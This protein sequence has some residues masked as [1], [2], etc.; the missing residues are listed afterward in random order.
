MIL[1]LIMILFSLPISAISAFASTSGGSSGGTQ[2]AAVDPSKPKANVSSLYYELRDNGNYWVLPDDS[3]KFYF[4][5]YLDKAPESGEDV[6]VYY[7]T[8]DESA[9]SE[10]GDYES[11]GTQGDKY[12]TLARSND[13]RARVTVKSSII[14]DGF[15]NSADYIVSRSFYFDLI[16]VEGDAAVI[17]P[18]KTNKFENTSRL[19]CTLRAERYHPYVVNSYDSRVWFNEVAGLC[20]PWMVQIWPEPLGDTVYTYQMGLN[21]SDAW[22]NL[23]ASGYYDLGVSMY[24]WCV[25]P[26][27]DD[28][29]ILYTTLMYQKH[30]AWFPAVSLY[31]EGEWD[32][33]QY[34]GWERAY[35]YIEKVESGAYIWDVEKD[36]MKDNFLGFRVYDNLGN[37]EYEVYEPITTY[38]GVRWDYQV[39][40]LVAKLKQALV[41]GMLLQSSNRHYY[42]SALH[43]QDVYYLKVPSSFIN[44]DG[45][46]ITIESKTSHSPRELDL[47]LVASLIE[48]GNPTIA[49]TGTGNNQVKMVKTNI[50]E[51]SSG[52][53]IRLSVRFDRP[54]QVNNPENCYVTA[55]ING[56]YD[57]KLK[58]VDRPIGDTLVFEG[59]I[60]NEAK[61]IRIQNLRNIAFNKDCIAN[62]TNFLNYNHLLGDGSI[63]DI[64]SGYDCDLRAPLATVNT[65]KSESWAKSKSVDI[66]VSAAGTSARFED[67]VTVYY[68]W[69][70]TTAKPEKY[71]SKVT[72][73]TANDGVTMKSIVGTGDGEMYLHLMA[74]SR[75]GKTTVSMLTAEGKTVEYNDSGGVAYRPFG[76]YRFD[77]V[78]PLMD[79]ANIKLG[80]TAK[81]R[82]LSISL[83]NDGA[84]SGTTTVRLYHEYLIQ[85]TL[86]KTFTLSDF[87]DGEL[88]TPYKFPVEKLGIGDNERKILY[89][90][91]EFVDKVGNTRTDRT[92]TVTFDTNNYLDAEIIFAGAT[93]VRKEIDPDSTFTDS[94]ELVTEDGVITIFDYGKHDSPSFFVSNEVGTAYYAWSFE[95]DRLAFGVSDYDQYEYYSAE[96]YYNGTKLDP[97][98]YKL[99]YKSDAD[100]K[101]H[102]ILWFL[103]EIRSGRY[104]IRLVRTSP[105]S[106]RHS[107]LY[108]V[109]ATNDKED[110]TE[111]REKVEAGTLLTNNVYQISTPFYYKDKTGLVCTKNYN[112]TKLAAS[113]SSIAKA[114][115]YIY[116]NELSDIYV[117]KLTSTLALALK[118]GTSGYLMADREDTEPTEGQYWIRYKS[119]DWTPTSGESYW[120][121]YFYGMSGELYEGAFSANLT[122]AINTVANRIVSYGKITILTDASII[123]GSTTSDKLLDKYGMPYLNE[124]QLHTADEISTHTI[125]GNK[126]RDGV[127]YSA[128]TDIYRSY[129][130]VGEVGTPEYKEYPLVGN[131]AMPTGSIIQYMSYGDYNG[132]NPEWQDIGIEE[133]SNFID[134]F[135]SSG[136]HY[137]REI[138]DRGVSIFAVWLD[139]EAPVLEFSKTDDDGNIVKIPVDG[140]EIVDIRARDVIFGAFD[141]SEV[142]KY[143]YVAVYKVSDLSLVKIYTAD[144]LSVSP[145]RISDGNY[146]IVVADR[147]GNHFTITAKVNSAP[148]ACDI[149]ES[150]DRFI[151]LTCNRRKDQIVRYEV[152]L[153]GELLTSTY[154]EERTF[155][156]T[157]RYTIHIQ[158]IYGN[159]FNKTYDFSRS[160]PEITWKYL[161]EDGWYY[162]YDPERTI[163]SGF[164]MSDIING[165]C[166]ISTSVSSRFTFKGNYDFQFIGTAPQYTKTTGA[167]TVVTIAAGQSFTVKIYYKEYPDNYIIYT[168]VVD[169]MSPTV[170][171]FAEVDVPTNGE[172]ALFEEWLN[173][174]NISFS[175]L[176]YTATKENKVVGNGTIISSD[177]IRINAF[178]ENNLLSVQ[179]FVDDVLVKSQDSNTGFPQ[180]VLSRWGSYRIEAK[181]TLGNT[182]VHVFENGKPDSVGYYVDGKELEIDIHSYLNF[183]DIDGVKTYTGL[184]YGHES[185]KLDVR[186]NADIFMSIGVSGDNTVIYGFRI[187]DGSIYPI[188]YIISEIT[189]TDG[190]KTRTERQIDIKVGSAILTYGS[191][192]FLTNKEYLV[193]K[194]G[195]YAVY[196]SVDFDRIVTFKVYASDDTAKIV[197]VNARVEYAANGTVFVS[198]K[199][200]KMCSTIYFNDIDGDDI[201]GVQ[202]GTDIRVN[203]GF[204]I[205]EVALAGQYVSGLRLYYSHL[206]DLTLDSLAG[207][208]DIY[209]PDM[210]YWEDGFYLLIAENRFGNES[211]YRISISREFGVTSSVVFSDGQ[212]LYY[213]K[214]YS[215]KMYSDHEIIIDIINDGVAYVVVRNGRV[216]TG[217]TVKNEGA[218]IYLVFSEVGDYEI[219][220][221]DSY[222]NEIRRQMQIDK[223]EYNVSEQLLTGYNEKALKREQGY[224]NQKL[225]VSK[226]VYDRD[227]LYYLAIKYGDTTHV[228][229]DSFSE[230]PVTT[231][232]S[233]LVDII[234][235]KGD[236][237]YTVICRNRFGAVET[238]EIHYRGTSPLI[239]ERTTRSSSQKESYD[240]A[241]ANKIGF[242]SNNSLIFSTEAESYIFKINGIV[243]ECPRTLVFSSTDDLASAEYDISYIDEYGFE[244]SFKAH[245]VRKTVTISVPTGIGGIEID[246]ILNTKNDICVTFDTQAYA[247]YTLNGGEPVIYN[248]QDVLKRD[249]IYRFTVVDYAGNVASFV[250]KKDTIAEFS[251]VESNS[252]APVRNGGVVNSNKVDFEPLNKDSSYIEGVF[253]DGV[254]QA[255]Y[256]SDRFTEDGKWEII[257]SDKLGNKSYF[258]FYIITRSV[259]GFAY[260]TPYEYR[261]SELWFESGDGS[262]ISYMSFVDQ[263]EDT[264]SFNFTENGKYTVVMTSLSTGISSKFNFTV[265]TAP[266]EVSLVGCNNGETTVND[267]TLS[268]CKVGD[269]IKI[270]KAS[271]S[272]ETL[273]SEV[274]VTSYTTQMPI[275]NEGGEYR[276]VVESEAGVETE[277]T[278]VRKH[279][280]NTAGSVFII[281]IITVCIIGLFVGLVYRNKSKTDN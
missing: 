245:L 116:Y 281:I 231:A 66:Y 203:D 42:H 229:F 57:I 193:S 144:E 142:D 239:L 106:V 46:A 212:K 16:R 10:W 33:N 256:N 36:Y 198:T 233:D 75:S 219:T 135:T 166:K 261:I 167:E 215:A 56:V 45:F 185:L 11:V 155:H 41:D 48:T 23:I 139:K 78:A 274:E 88:K 114:K 149:K 236:G 89:F 252:S 227:G 190:D 35:D 29:G 9:V 156:D 177:L 111:L 34:L 269:I 31:M 120:V 259:N 69:T 137:I 247:T 70:K 206:N 192:N 145:A 205:E 109:Y 158:D 115:E 18:N 174:G 118:N 82:T 230:T 2:T 147:S 86:L 129:I 77:N 170:N 151:K 195:E 221:S 125:C 180:L 234:G 162:N 38:D 112:S 8:M 12:V 93:D 210:C 15:S 249:G 97:G 183:E 226:A 207:R 202:V 243:T 175:D 91:L 254:F 73:Y 39:D 104:E 128:D 217:F 21:F 211:V 153:D 121:Y 220:L 117:E 240:L 55:S 200:S 5:I 196:A 201:I 246:G 235:S 4:D 188:S 30:G 37:V 107:P 168:G 218:L 1:V 257:V 6:V 123:V 165:N 260:T 64:I 279:I 59:A 90:H 49:T 277:L 94:T 27:L 108:V 266:P 53:P 67:F 164:S 214:E 224:T 276:I 85:N 154:A 173:T 272:G 241:L 204:V 213:S 92:F 83:P 61:N 186:N 271:G 25:E 267:V 263:G 141:S 50:N 131:F 169:V 181:D 194:A 101:W 20:A 40:P 54:V 13:Y 19:K 197:T 148:L 17:N 26:G 47:T 223:S 24:G 189:V 22:R 122:E 250:I 208:E 65:T 79:S 191:D 152:Y 14:G 138:S 102:F 51:L 150:T 251:F 143:S 176:F 113:F 163:E 258:C 253:K 3:G 43:V 178:D 87:V 28:D 273:V 98:E 105:D 159:D 126:W 228:L 275:I 244:Y 171:V 225:S 262:R 209:V 264:S 222:G 84:G 80:G 134:V 161:A 7:R 60:P 95:V 280:M 182:T 268:G 130:G 237:V 32:D 133:D 68:E 74:I 242:W 132:E 255:G 146:Y 232:A 270:Y 187:E 184:E 52:D 71:S 62:I 199:L 278:F 172:Y 110:R 44:G 265:N 179:V 119:K 136:L 99:Q 96:V 72:L 124:L 76:Y 127:A 103:T 140:Y 81:E 157:G 100:Y 58:L 248:S 216:Y 63:V 238:K 160:Y